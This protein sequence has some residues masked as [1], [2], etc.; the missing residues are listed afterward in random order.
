MM[1]RMIMGAAQLISSV[2]IEGTDDGIID[3]RCI[4][5]GIPDGMSKRELNLRFP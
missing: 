1:R 3:G 2:L 4:D 5:Q